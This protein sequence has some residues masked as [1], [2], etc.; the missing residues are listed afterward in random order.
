MPARLCILNKNFASCG[1]Y[2][3][4]TLTTT[5]FGV[6]FEKKGLAYGIPIMVFR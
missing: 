1:V 3:R 6:C 2:P 5:D 4:G